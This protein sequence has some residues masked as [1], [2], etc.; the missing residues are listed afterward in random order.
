MKMGWAAIASSMAGASRVLCEELDMFRELKVS[1]IPYNDTVIFDRVA[2]KPCC[3]AY[4][5]TVA[6]IY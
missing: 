5:I 6:V 1:T 2:P 3:T 4:P